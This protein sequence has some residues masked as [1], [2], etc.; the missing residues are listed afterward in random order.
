M[1]NGGG[2]KGGAGIVIV[3]YDISPPKGTLILMR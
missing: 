1:W 3:R 2:G